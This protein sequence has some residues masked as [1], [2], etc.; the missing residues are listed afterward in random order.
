MPHYV[1][2][3]V[4]HALNQRSK[5]VHG[6]R[7]LVMGLSYKP[8]IDDVRESPSFELIEALSELGAEVDYNDPHVPHTHRMRKHDL[9]MHSVNLTPAEVA[10][11]DC[12]LIATHHKVYDWQM[13]A[14]NARLIVDSRNAMANVKGRRDHIVLA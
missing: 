2:E 5:A 8:D 4:Q 6:A 9:Q 3:R 14:D 7:I 12:V 1:V 13:I 11:Y 10:R